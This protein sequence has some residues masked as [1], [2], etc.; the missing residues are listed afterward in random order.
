MGHFSNRYLLCKTVE[1]AD[2]GPRIGPINIPDEVLAS[3]SAHGKWEQEQKRMAQERIAAENDARREDASLSRRLEAMT[4][5]RDNAFA[6]IERLDQ[7]I[8]DAIGA[9][10]VDHPVAKRLARAR[11][12]G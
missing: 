5:T 2:D 10:G 6:E 7:A 3:T 11:S 4:A 9:L 8:D 1:V 12:A